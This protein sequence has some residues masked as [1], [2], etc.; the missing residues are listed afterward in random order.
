MVP[1]RGTDKDFLVQIGGAVSDD[2][3]NNNLVLLLLFI[4]LFLSFFQWCTDF[5]K[6]FV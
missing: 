1:E 5:K 2:N 4:L 6:V 3:T